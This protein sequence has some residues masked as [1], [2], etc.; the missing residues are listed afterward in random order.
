L[1][2]PYRP[3]GWYLRAIV[4]VSTIVSALGI[5]GGLRALL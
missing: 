4:A 5:F 3:R 1:P 2:E